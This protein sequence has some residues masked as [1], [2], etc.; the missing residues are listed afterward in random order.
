MERKKMKKLRKAVSL[1]AVMAIMATMFAAPLGVNAA[2]ETN[3]I[4][5]SSPN[6]SPNAAVNPPEGFN[7]AT[8]TGDSSNGTTLIKGTYYKIGKDLIGGAG[9]MTV[10]YAS[11][12]AGVDS[13]VTINSGAIATNAK[14]LQSNIDSASRILYETNVNVN[15]N[16]SSVALMMPA[17]GLQITKN[18]DLTNYQGKWVNLKIYYQP[19][20]TYAYTV[21]GIQKSFS[22]S[23]MREEG[24]SSYTADFWKTLLSG[25]AANDTYDS[26]KT[27]V[28]KS[29]VYGNCEAY[30]NGNLVLNSN[31][32]MPIRQSYSTSTIPTRFVFWAAD[33]AK[34]KTVYYS[35]IKHSIITNYSSDVQSMSPFT[36][37]SKDGKYVS[38][39]NNIYIKEGTKLSDIT[40]NDGYE[41]A[42][43]TDMTAGG[44]YP[45]VP[46]DGVLAEN[47]AIVVRDSNYQ[48][49]T[50]SVKPNTAIT[51]Y[52]FDGS[53]DLGLTKNVIKSNFNSLSGKTSDDKSYQLPLGDFDINGVSTG[54]TDLA[55]LN[56][57]VKMSM[58]VLT[59]EN[60]EN[61]KFTL[62]TVWGN[63][64]SDPVD[65]SRLNGGQW[66][67][68]DFIIS[69]KGNTTDDKTN[70]T[71]KT[72]I[73]G[74][75]IGQKNGAASP[76]GTY[77]Q[78]L[79]GDY[80]KGTTCEVIRM[81]TSNFS[82]DKP[83]YIDDI[84]ITMHKL[85]VYPETMPTAITAADGDQVATVTAKGARV[86]TD[87]TYSTQL[88]D[89]T[90]KAGNIIVTEQNGLY[91]YYTVQSKYTE[92]DYT[93]MTIT[94]PLNMGNV[95]VSL[96]WSQ[97]GIG[98]KS[99]DDYSLKMTSDGTA[100][101][102]YLTFE[103][104]RA[105]ENYLVFKFNLLIPST[106]KNLGRIFIGENSHNA[107]SAD[108]RAN[109]ISRDEWHEV[110]NIKEYPDYSSKAKYTTYLDGSKLRDGETVT[111]DL[112]KG[113]NRQL[114]IISWGND[115]DNP[116][117][118]EVYIDDFVIYR[119]NT[120]PTV[121]PQELTNTFDG[122]IK[123]A[124]GNTMY[125][126]AGA[127]V[128]QAKAII[129]GKYAAAPVK[130]INGYKVSGNTVLADDATL[131]D[132]DIIV[133][134]TTD[135]G[136]SNAGLK[137]Y[138]YVTV[139]SLPSSGIIAEKS[140][141]K[142]TD[143]ATAHAFT[144]ES[145]YTFVAAEYDKDGN[146]VQVDYNTNSTISL[147]TKTA[148]NTVKLFLIDGFGNLRPLAENA[149]IAVK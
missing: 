23:I 27:Y 51:M 127:T 41:M 117:A 116:K 125:I 48:M 5:Y 148:G 64:I 133:Y 7:I 107:I 47:N 100:Q 139:K 90:L 143:T 53:T 129:K 40:L 56:G 126:P 29:A 65:A 110:T 46:A 74:K 105:T 63:S 108:I 3:K 118:T 35:N 119:S 18:I 83:L 31:Y 141:V 94:S 62:K 42:A 145:G 97:S 109:D 80:Y 34:A 37:E 24:Y 106:E 4:I 75:Q 8:A 134:E 96:N 146:M 98:G 84:K 142:A 136:V 111:N 138:S 49:R 140:S 91:A 39:K 93:L 72:Y 54:Q 144:T 20:M 81:A 17:G 33:N 52:Q 11:Q 86:Y 78:N 61:A 66:N 115:K 120:A 95:K 101:D 21:D 15:S 85:A 102:G 114:R 59:A 19:L 73:N 58:N 2:D 79:C 103:Y 28:L 13:K 50:Y 32:P 6:L 38:D 121:A 30:I 88:T 68:L 87:R 25:S 57:Y 99:I 135:N 130:A 89:G 132:G 36:N 69:L 26:T 123:V 77:L 92:N 113:N 124:D 44:T 43:Y 10:A 14:N 16:I 55:K 45:T 71:V 122:D 70:A 149:E 128:A 112:S 147:T 76:Y 131:T 12:A 60:S 1:V 104:K 67:H 137:T 9:D 22:T 82:G